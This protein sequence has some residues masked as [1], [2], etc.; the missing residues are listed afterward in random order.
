MNSHQD[1]RTLGNPAV[2]TRIFSTTDVLQG[3]AGIKKMGEYQSNASAACS[4]HV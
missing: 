3:A 4:M 1:T 2:G